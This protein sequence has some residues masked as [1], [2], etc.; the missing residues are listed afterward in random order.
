ML[1]CVTFHVGMRD[2]WMLVGV[3]F[4]YVAGAVKNC[5]QEE[6]ESGLSSSSFVF[7]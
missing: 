5:V 1:V 7:G 2:F 6:G 3:V 4:E